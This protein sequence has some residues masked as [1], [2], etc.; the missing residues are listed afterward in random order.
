MAETKKPKVIKTKKHL[1]RQQREAKQ[2]RIII[3]TT[4]VIGAIVLGLVGYGLINQLI[5]RPRIPVAKVGDTVIRVNEFETQVKYSRIQM[6]N[7]A[8]QYFS[9][10]QQ[11]GDFGQ[12][13][14]QA[15]QGIVTQLGQPEQLGSQ[16]LDDM[17]N[18]ILIRE[19]AAERGITV[20]KEEIDQALQEAFGFFPNG[21]PTPEITITLA[22]TPTLSETQLALVPPTSTPAATE[23]PADELEAT[24]TPEVIEEVEEPEDGSAGTPTPEATPTIT[25]TPTPYTT[26]VFA[27]NI[28]EFRDFYKAFGFSID[29]LRDIIEVELL[30]DRLVEQITADLDPVKEEVW[31][32][33]ILVETEEEAQ[34]I[35][36][37]LAEGEEFVKLAATNSLDDS[38][39]DLGGDLGWFDQQRMVPE[40]ADAAFNLEIGEVSEPV[41]TS[42]GFHIIQLLGRRDSQVTPGELDELKAAAFDEWLNE[43]RTARKDITIYD[44]WVDHVPSTPEVPQELLYQLFQQ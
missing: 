36:A 30:R 6:L 19:E 2:T 17:I 22:A 35:L 43:I 8:Y 13:F 40:F 29:N 4:I 34:D 16:V 23:L 39:K 37:R 20:S 27:E 11:F 14:L 41:Q 44:E 24:A 18:Y 10:Y 5:V 42:F 32:R 15:A 26:E 9:Y 33:H 28:E 7:Q 3:I 38:N 31:A 12:D 25:L 1:A 21:T